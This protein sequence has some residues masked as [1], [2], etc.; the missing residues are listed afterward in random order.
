MLYVN[1]AM[2]EMNETKESTADNKGA[3]AT[4]LGQGLNSPVQQKTVHQR[5]LL[6]KI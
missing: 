5:K 6:S 3:K 4:A 1:W 2:K